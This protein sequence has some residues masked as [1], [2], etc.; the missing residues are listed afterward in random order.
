MS[1]DAGGVTQSPEG[2]ELW[3]AKGK[4]KNIPIRRG[5]KQN[6]EMGIEKRHRN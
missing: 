1:V 4:G 2:Y 6:T 5:N 3:A